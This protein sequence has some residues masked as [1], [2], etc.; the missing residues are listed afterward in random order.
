MFPNMPSPSDDA[1]LALELA[2]FAEHGILPRAGGIFDQD[3]W[4]VML[5]KAGLAAFAEKRE[6]DNKRNAKK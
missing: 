3:N 4:H 5:I 6:Q 2:M 1:D